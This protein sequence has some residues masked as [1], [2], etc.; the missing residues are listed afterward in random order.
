MCRINQTSVTD[1][2]C[3]PLNVLG[4]GAPSQAALNYINTTSQRTG[5]ATEFDVTANIVGDSS[6]LFEL[7]RRSG[8]VRTRRRISP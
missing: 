7:P 1:P 3:V 2:N 4:N 6:Q 5:K 8:P